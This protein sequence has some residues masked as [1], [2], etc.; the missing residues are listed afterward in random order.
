MWLNSKPSSFFH[1]LAFIHSPLLPKCFSDLSHWPSHLHKTG[2]AVH[3]ALLINEMQLSFTEMEKKLKELGAMFKH[4]LMSFVFSRWHATLHLA[5]S[6]GR[7][8]GLS[9]RQSVGPSVCRPIGLSHFW[10]PGGFC[11]TAP[12]QPSATVPMSCRVSGLVIFYKNLV[13]KNIK[14]WKR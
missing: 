10:I 12:A 9:A 8:V 3:T 1:F 4:I 13:Y 5:V 7:S 6:I 14:P 2:V 11:F